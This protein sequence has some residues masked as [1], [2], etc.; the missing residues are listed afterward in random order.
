MIKVYCSNVGVEAGTENCNYC[1]IRKSCGAL[2][3]AKRLSKHQG[4]K[5]MIYNGY[6]P[7]KDEL[8]EFLNRVQNG[9]DT[10]PDDVK[11][12]GD[13]PPSLP[14]VKPFKWKNIKRIYE[15]NNF[16]IDL[17]TKDNTVRVSIF[18][19]GHFQDEVFV[20]KEDYCG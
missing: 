2:K 20:R 14:Y 7:E 16:V 18:D 4:E 6:E 10:R 19:S 8:D 5:D 3:E 12:Y 11:L 17:F 9:E 15:D 13:Y 1:I